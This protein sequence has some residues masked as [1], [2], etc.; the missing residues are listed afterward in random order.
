MIDADQISRSLTAAGGAALPAI[1]AIFG[2]DLIDASTQ[3]LNRPRMRELVFSD[4]AARQR[5]EAIVHP[6]IGEESQRQELLAAVQQRKLLVHDL[7]LLV[8][9]PHWRSQLDAILVV[10]CEENTQIERVMQ[11]SQLSREAIA[12][13]LQAQAS[14]SQRLA[15]A[16]W[17][18]YND[19]GVTIGALHAFTDELADWF[20]L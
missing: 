2:G 8:E 12:A 10:D 11:R 16:D 13:I 6:L 18:I 9:A 5:L 20:G 19:G 17:V 4:P 7:P 3:A 15:A 14:R 1:A